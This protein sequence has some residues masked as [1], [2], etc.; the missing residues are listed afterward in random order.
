MPNVHIVSK[1]WAASRL[2]LAWGW[3]V[4][5]YPGDAD[6]FLFA[7]KED[8]DPSLYGYPRHASTKSNPAKDSF[9]SHFFHTWV[10]LI[11]MVGINRGAQLLH[12][13]NGGVIDQATRELTYN[14]SYHNKEDVIYYPESKC[15][16]F[17][18]KDDEELFSLIKRNFGL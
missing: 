5:Q 11:P 2:F 6:L 10:D 12:V 1:D 9:E 16:C 8:V 15:L 17:N 4:V 3:T 14:H 13:M 18:K 7:G